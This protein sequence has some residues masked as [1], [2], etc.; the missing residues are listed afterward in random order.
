MWSLQPKVAKVEEWRHPGGISL[1]FPFTV[2]SD[3]SSLGFQRRKV[4]GRPEKD[5]VIIIGAGWTGALQEGGSAEGIFCRQP[6]LGSLPPWLSCCA[7]APGC[8]QKNCPSWQK[9]V[10]S[11][12]FLW[13]VACKQSGCSCSQWCYKLPASNPL[14]MVVTMCVL[15]LLIQICIVHQTTPKSRTL[16]SLWNWLTNCVCFVE[17]AQRGS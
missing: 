16:Q 8:Q 9:M 11:G 2:E 17:Y 6:S 7:T 12:W 1:S 14:S 13:L 5:W 4:S 10:W 3:F 15:W